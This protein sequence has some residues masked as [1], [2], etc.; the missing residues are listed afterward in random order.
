MFDTLFGERAYGW[1]FLFAFIAV[2][3]LIA[4]TVWLLRRFRGGRAGNLA[5]RGSHAR[6]AVIDAADVDGRRRLVLIRRGNLEHL[7][8]IGGA[9]DVVV[10]RNIV[11]GAG[12]AREAAPVRSSAATDAL[13]R[14]VP[15]AEGTMRPLQT[16]LA[17]RL[18][19]VSR[20]EPVAR[21]EPP[22]CVETAPPRLR[23]PPPAAIVAEPMQW[24]KSERAPVPPPP[25]PLERGPVVDLFAGLA[26]RFSREPA[27]APPPP[28]ETE[29]NSSA[30]QN[31]IELM[32]RL[33][34]ALPRPVQGGD[35]R[36]AQGTARA[37]PTPAAN[38]EEIAAA[39]ASP[40]AR[41]VPMAGGAEPALPDTRP[42]PAD[43]KP[44]PRKSI[45]D[46]LEQE[47]DRPADN[48]AAEHREASLPA[49]S[50]VDGGRPR[51]T[52]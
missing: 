43:T 49:P 21:S 19:P 9:T 51:Q 50:K 33:E 48:M 35:R 13:P 29:F 4:M 38:D 42:L 32:Q 25:A 2:L 14:P 31:L 7:L 1:H 30:D 40:P 34:A 12:P 11:R 15:R 28:A 27:P 37:I 8:M 24:S 20:A 45:Y 10:E 17:P 23:P 46:S 36:A 6:L 47:L 44:A 26:Q 16:V 5:T 52:R 3:G 39:P 22:P 18:E 41:P